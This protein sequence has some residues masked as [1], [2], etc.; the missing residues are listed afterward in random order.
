MKI[1]FMS[2]LSDKIE[3]SKNIGSSVSYTGT[4]RDNISIT[5]PTIVI[6]TVIPIQEFISKYNYCYIEDFKRYY[7]IVDYTILSDKLIEVSLSV[8][9]LMTYRYDIYSLYGFIDRNEYEYNENIEDTK[10]LVVENGNVAKHVEFDRS[11]FIDVDNDTDY[12]S[13]I[14][15][16][17][18][19][20]NFFV[21]NN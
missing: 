1:I 7:Y 3:V 18:S 16:S 11:P 9:V 17:I 5:S 4:L 13:K 14:N 10:C 2:N 12:Q 15:V 20:Y 19:G 21:S 8:D 6:D